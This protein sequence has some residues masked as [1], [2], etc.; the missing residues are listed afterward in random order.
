MG[1]FQGEQEGGGPPL[2]QELEE[3]EGGWNE[4]QGAG[5]RN[6]RRD[7]RLEQVVEPSACQKGSENAG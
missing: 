4:A 5:L 7:V 2:D 3:E 6:R 1:G